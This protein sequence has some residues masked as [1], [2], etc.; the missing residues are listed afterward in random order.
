MLIGPHLDNGDDIGIK[1]QAPLG[2]LGELVV[3]LLHGLRPS[4]VQRCE[5]VEHVEAERHE[6]GDA[7]E[8]GHTRT[9]IVGCWNHASAHRL[10]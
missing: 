1:G 6:P 9:A 8:I 4:G 10:S 3:P 5:V 2:D 7:Q